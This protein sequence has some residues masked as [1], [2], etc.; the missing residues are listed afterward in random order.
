MAAILI[1]FVLF[2][3]VIMAVGVWYILQRRRARA[4]RDTSGPADIVNLD[5]LR[6][7]A[8]FAKDQNARI[9]EYMRTNW[10]GSHVELPGVLTALLIELER[11]AMARKLIVDRDSLKIMLG[12]SLRA[13]KLCHAHLVREALD[14]VA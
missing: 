7:L 3:I 4:Q 11:D 5:D 13:H 1:P 6:T 2:I 9:G 12:G 8:T 14:K 10:S